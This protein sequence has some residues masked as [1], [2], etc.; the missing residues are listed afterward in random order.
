MIKKFFSLLLAL[1][2]TVSLFAQQTFTDV[3]AEKREVGAFNGINVAEGI[4]LVLTMGSREE[5]AVSASTAEFR[6]RIV[7]EVRDGVLKI[8]F[9]P[10]IKLDKA[11][12]RM[13]KDLRVYVACKSLEELRATSGAG[14]KLSGVLSGN[15]IK[16]SVNT[17]ATLSG[18]VRFDEM[19]IDQS[20]GSEVLLSGTVRQFTAG[21]STGSMLKG[22]GLTTD[23]CNISTDTGAGVYITVQKQLAVKASTGSFV[24]Y[25]GEGSVVDAKTNT[26]GSVKR[27]KNS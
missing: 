16:V 24:K 14:V 18:E 25:K 5:V 6:N 11:Q 15:K 23:N 22:E 8:H 12:K 27:I 9:R 7:T 17:G 20:T 1:T 13:R 2:A 10:E 4:E 26:G 21:G 19:L 3:N